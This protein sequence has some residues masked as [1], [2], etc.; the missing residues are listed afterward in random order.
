MI[1]FKQNTDISAA[2]RLDFEAV[3]QRWAKRCHT[4]LVSVLGSRAEA[5]AL[6]GEVLQQLYTKQNQVLNAENP[7]TYALR[8]ATNMARSHLRSE[9]R[10]RRR[11]QPADT[12]VL[13]ANTADQSQPALEA[14]TI[15]QITT[16]LAS[17]P[18]DQREVVALKIWDGRTFTEIGD[19][20]DC[21]TNTAASRWRYAC[22]K[23]RKQLEGILD[24]R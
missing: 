9:I 2:K 15:S 17:L 20:C 12:Q 1:P 6:L 10:R 3:Y 11:E 23:L 13:T 7:D 21:S 24:E 18:A 5:E 14:E 16:A 22:E 4:F 19:I 8:C